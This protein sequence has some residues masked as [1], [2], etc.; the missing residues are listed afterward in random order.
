MFRQYAK[1]ECLMGRAHDA[2]PAREDEL[3]SLLEATASGDR[4][5]FR[6]LYGKAAPILFAVCMRL[7]RE[8]ETAQD[9][10]QEAMVRI[11]S[12]AHLFDA[13]KGN[14]LGW[15]TVVTRNC[16]LSRIAAAPPP[17]SSLDEVL[18]LGPNPSSGDPSA[19]ADLRRC[20]GQLNERY[21]TCVTLI[22]LHGLSYE[23]LAAH[24]K[25]PLGSVKSW[26]HRALRELAACMGP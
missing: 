3:S 8:R 14:A 18:D 4:K 6:T 23:E 17:S 2:P 19:A 22:H 7:M 16:A 10:L 25:A 15:M 24:M 13:A 1:R 26:V 9:V 5:A 11:W 12:K 21:R 20:L